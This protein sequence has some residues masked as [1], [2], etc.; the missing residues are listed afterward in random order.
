MLLGMLV[1]QPQR[2]VMYGRRPAPSRQ[3]LEARA[4]ACAALFLAG[5]AVHGDNT[6]K[7]RGHT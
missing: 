1:F 5:A 7:Q 4:K 6:H 3:E 2:D